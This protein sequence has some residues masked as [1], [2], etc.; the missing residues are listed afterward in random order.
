MHVL[1]SGLNLSVWFKE[2]KIKSIIMMRKYL[3]FFSYENGFLEYLKGMWSITCSWTN[4]QKFYQ[5]NDNYGGNYTKFVFRI[6]RTIE[7]RKKI[8]E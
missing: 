4:K 7:E 8:D 3:Y 2:S 5:K 6:N 1:L